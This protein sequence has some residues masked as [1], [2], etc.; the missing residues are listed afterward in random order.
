MRP[1]LQAFSSRVPPQRLGGPGAAPTGPLDA[2][3]FEERGKLGCTY[4]A[5]VR[6]QAARGPKD[7]G[8]GDRTGQGSGLR[9]VGGA[10]DAA[11]AAGCAAAPEAAETEAAAVRNQIMPDPG[12]HGPQR[13][14][15]QGRTCAEQETFPA[16]YDLCPDLL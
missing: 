14:C 4:T 11:S 6:T 10:E 16:A 12:G 3:L 9:V 13:P 15:A 7:R 1:R 2:G 5:A 8:M